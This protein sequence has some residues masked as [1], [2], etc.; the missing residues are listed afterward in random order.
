[1]EKVKINMVGGGFQH[2]NSS[3]INQY[4]KYI[5]WIK[6]NH[7]A[8]ISMH[9]DYAI[10]QPSDKTKRNFAW[11]SEISV[12]NQSLINWVPSHIEFLENNF[13]LIFTHDKRLLSLSSKIKLVPCSSSP[14]IVNHKIYPKTK[15]VSMIASTKIMCPAHAYRQEIAVKFAD[16]LDLYGSGRSTFIETKEQGLIDYCFSIAMENDNYPNC[17]TEKITDCFATGTIPIYWG[18]P[19]VS[20]FFNDNGIIFL[21]NDFQIEKLSVD[22]YYSKMDFIKENFEIASNWPIGEDYIYEHYIK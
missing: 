3:T 8:N 10:T 19:A 18:T 14:W 1:M 22:L 12:I 13:E 11:I 5:E 16:K 9:I 15:L 4:P 17:I 6:G 21:T 2:V 20:E 7:T